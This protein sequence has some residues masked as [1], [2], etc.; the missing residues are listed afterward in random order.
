[1]K[2][3]TFDIIS[4][5]K[6]MSK[7]ET[8]VCFIFLS[9]FFVSLWGKH[10]AWALTAA[11]F[12]YILCDEIKQL[13]KRIK[14]LPYVELQ[15]PTEEEIKQSKDEQYGSEVH[16][17]PQA[18]DKKISYPNTRQEYNF[19]ANEAILNN[20]YKDV[21]VDR[22]KKL[23]SE[24]QQIIFDGKYLDSKD[25]SICFIEIKIMKTFVSYVYIS[26]RNMLNIIN[27]YSLTVNTDARLD[28]ILCSD[29]TEH[30]KSL[31]ENQFKD[32]IKTEKLKIIYISSKELDEYIRN[33]NK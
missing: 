29:I 8:A 6:T 4:W 31:L 20:L 21:K 10:D 15:N 1:M 19:L 7:K 30:Q 28:F 18:S 27:S 14:K 12:L 5:L 16:N 24:N 17:F 13:I 33:Y 2:D 9:I 3:T 32:Y 23:V 11:L 25:G 22:E 26:I